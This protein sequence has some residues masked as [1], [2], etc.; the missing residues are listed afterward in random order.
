MREQ[1]M[2]VV[3]A[4]ASRVERGFVERSKRDSV[5][6]SVEG[7]IDHVGERLAADASGFRRYGCAVQGGWVE[8]AEVDDRNFGARPVDVVGSRVAAPRDAHRRVLGT[9]FE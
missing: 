9:R 6:P 4:P 3:E 1:L 2:L 5:D 7:E 8:V